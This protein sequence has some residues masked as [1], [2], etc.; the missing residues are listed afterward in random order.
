MEEAWPPKPS[1]LR[2]AALGLAAGAK[3][4]AAAVG[5]A[6]MVSPSRVAPAIVTELSGEDEVSPGV[7]TRSARHATGRLERG[8]VHV[9]AAR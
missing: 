6:L 5:K 3:R 1:P 9:A 8:L 4:A 2:A 7:P